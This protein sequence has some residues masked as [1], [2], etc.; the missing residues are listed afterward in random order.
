MEPKGVMSI[1]PR[2]RGRLGVEVSFKYPLVQKV[3]RTVFD[4]RT[5]QMPR[6]ILETK[7]LMVPTRVLLWLH[8][9]RGRPG[10]GKWV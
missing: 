6:T 4:T 7:E 8:G 9:V 5:E 3:Q 2:N 10:W 1:R